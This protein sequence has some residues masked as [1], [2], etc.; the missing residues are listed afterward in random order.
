M[1]S[2][3]WIPVTIYHSYHWPHSIGY[4]W[5]Q[6]STE[7]KCLFFLVPWYTQHWL[8]SSLSILSLSFLVHPPAFCQVWPS[9]PA[10]SSLS[11]L[12]S[13]ARAQQVSHASPACLLFS[14][15]NAPTRIWALIFTWTLNCLLTSPLTSSSNSRCIFLK[16]YLLMQLS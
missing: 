7:E 4:Y 13:R 12:W 3:F 1:A 9:T 14:F 8:E 6:A 11:C 2:Q 10:Q 5:P 15:S 16:Y